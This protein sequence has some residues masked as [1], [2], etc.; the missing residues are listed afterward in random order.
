MNGWNRQLGCRWHQK[1]ASHRWTKQKTFSP[2]VHSCGGFVIRADE[3]ERSASVAASECQHEGDFFSFFFCLFFLTTSPKL[4]SEKH[5][6]CCLLQQFCGVLGHTFMEFLKGSGDYCQ[7]QHA[8]YADEWTAELF[9]IHPTHLSHRRDLDSSENQQRVVGLDGVTLPAAHCPRSA[10][11][12]SGSRWNQ[13]CSS[14][15]FLLFFPFILNKEVFF[16]IYVLFLS[17]SSNRPLLTLLPQSQKNPEEGPE[18]FF[19]PKY[20]WTF[21]VFDPLEFHSAFTSSTS[22]RLFLGFVFSFG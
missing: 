2:S 22:G 3:Q 9:A 15:C 7:A 10:F 16:F 6:V 20:N 18:G 4:C 5:V 8:A 21:F 19:F 11:A 12:W 14:L 17:F 1:P 13:T